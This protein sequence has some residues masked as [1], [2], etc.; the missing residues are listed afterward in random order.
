MSI[1]DFENVK[2]TTITVIANLIGNACIEN[3]FPLLPVTRLDLTGI[4]RSTKKFKIPYPGREYAGSI[5]SAKC[6][7]IT[8]G[9]V[10]TTSNKSFRN[11]VAIDIC[12]SVKNISAKLV[13]NKI[14]MCGPNSKELAIEAAQ[15]ILDH[16]KNIQ[17][18]LD[19]IHQHPQ[20]RDETV[21]WLIR[22]TK[23]APFII[24]EETQEIIELQEGEA[25]RNCV[26][27]DKNGQVK[28]NYKEIPFKWEAGDTI[29]PDNVVV[30]KYGQPYYRSL[31]KKEK[32]DGGG[33]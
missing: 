24:N 3:A 20:E 22:E 14:H 32:K 2:I 5:F 9:I 31:T 13:K 29:N 15:H 19:Y 28:Y 21:K 8:R 11:A 17:L 6:A 18:E 7:G 23:G 12:T 26:I 4:S 30:N 1:V 25:I 27:Y 16:L 33:K 10:K